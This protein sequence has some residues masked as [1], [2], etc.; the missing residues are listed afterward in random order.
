MQVLW[1]PQCTDI[2]LDPAAV[3]HDAARMPQFHAASGGIL[4]GTRVRVAQCLHGRL[5]SFW[6]SWCLLVQRQLAVDAVPYSSSHAAAG[7]AAAELVSARD[8]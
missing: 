2:G 4:A 6:Q 7:A 1:L 5:G 8:A 3:R